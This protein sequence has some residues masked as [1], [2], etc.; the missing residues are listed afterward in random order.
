[1]VGDLTLL[2]AARVGKG[3]K[4]LTTG[5]RVEVVVGITLDLLLFPDL[6]GLSLSVDGA[7]HL[8]E[9][10]AGVHILP[11]RLTVLGVGAAAVVLL[12]TVVGEGNTTGSQSVGLSLLET[13]LVVEVAH[14]TGVVMVVNED[15]KGVNILE[16]GFLLVEAVLDAVHGLA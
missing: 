10:G 8:V 12:S 4:E 15:T 9:I 2:R 5:V 3:D 14:E 6:A 16:M 1:M 7:D 11:E 13:G